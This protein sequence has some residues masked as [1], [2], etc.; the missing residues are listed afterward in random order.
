[1]LYGSDKITTINFRIPV[2]ERDTFWGKASAYGTPSHVLREMVLAYNDG[3][4][5]IKPR[6]V[7]IQ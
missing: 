4:L 5:A 6:T 3:R 1:M 7:E 2:S